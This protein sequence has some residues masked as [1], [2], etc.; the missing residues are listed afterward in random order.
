MIDV[1]SFVFDIIVIEAQSMLDELDRRYLHVILIDAPVQNHVGQKI[2]VA[3]NRNPKWYR[4]LYDSYSSLKRNHTIKS[5][6]RIVDRKPNI[7]SVY[8]RMLLQL[9]EHRINNLESMSEE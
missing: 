6:K 2:R 3:D 4:D 1:E 8:D 9:I 7:D 5:L